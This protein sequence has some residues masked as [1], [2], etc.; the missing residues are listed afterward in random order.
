MTRT[1]LMVMSFA[2]VG[3]AAVASLP[4]QAKAPTA[5][6]SENVTLP[7]STRTLPEG[8]GL[9]TVQAN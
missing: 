2:L 5:L 8:S 7:E 3:A 9:V 1:V 6:K 4:A